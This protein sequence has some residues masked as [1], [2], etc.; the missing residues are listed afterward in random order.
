VARWRRSRSCRRRWLADLALGERQRRS[1]GVRCGEEAGRKNESRR[2][3]SRCHCSSK[4]WRLWELALS[5]TAATG[6]SA[7]GV[8][9]RCVKEG[10]RGAG[11]LPVAVLPAHPARG[12]I[13]AAVHDALVAVPRRWRLH[14]PAD[15]TPGRFDARPV[16]GRDG[17]GVRVRPRRPYGVARVQRAFF[18]GANAAPPR[19]PRRRP[20]LGGGLHHDAVGDSDSPAP[21]PRDRPSA[22]AALAPLRPRRIPASAG[23]AEIAPAP[24]WIPADLQLAVGSGTA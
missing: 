15:S 2:R 22:R 12:I 3:S 13:Q 7:G 23:E 4:A 1:I 16:P 9:S 8:A 20:D 11:P 14:R 17:C 24:R 6:S 10:R 21:A 19:S 18:W 5:S